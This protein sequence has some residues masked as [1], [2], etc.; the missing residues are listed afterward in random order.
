MPKAQSKPKPKAK[1]NGIRKASKRELKNIAEFPTTNTKKQIQDWLIEIYQQLALNKKELINLL[2][3]KFGEYFAEDFLSDMQTYAKD[4]SCE[5][6]T[7]PDSRE[8]NIVIRE[9]F[10]IATLSGKSK[11][12]IYK[13][14]LDLFS[15][16]FLRRL[17]FA[18]TSRSLN[19]KIRNLIFDRSIIESELNNGMSN[20]VRNIKKKL[21]ARG[22][23]FG[24]KLN[25]KYLDQLFHSDDNDYDNYLILK[26]IDH[27]SEQRKLNIKTIL[28]PK[29]EAV[30]Q[31][32]IQKLTA[33]G[34]VE[35][36]N[37]Q[38]CSN[39]RITE[40]RKLRREHQALKNITS[41]W[42]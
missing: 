38:S 26:V 2:W 16:S 32:A 6:Q 17:V 37:R 33:E 1:T 24:Y 12:E 41:R 15:V 11:S 25:L 8:C 30:V 13:F 39:D 18:L 4:L 19:Q 36:V 14:V 27:I 3:K 31:A 35:E 9:A 28:L 29:K 21:E 10:H 20:G 23:D 7:K 22:I 34:F 5:C 40:N 42:T